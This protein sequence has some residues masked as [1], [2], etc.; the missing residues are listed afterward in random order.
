MVAI[1]AYTWHEWVEG[2]NT[3]VLYGQHLNACMDYVSALLNKG[4]TGANVATGGIDAGALIAADIVGETHLDYTRASGGRILQIGKN[5]ATVTGQM[6]VKGTS[7]ITAANTTNTDITVYFT[8]G[9]CCTAGDPAF[10]GVPMVWADV[11][12]ADKPAITIKACATNSC[13]INVDPASTA[14]FA[15]DWTVYWCAVGNK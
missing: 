11:Y 3:E 1:N 6:L 10:T 5:T 8:G 12:T 4:V 9:D 13:L 14:T 2:T 7:L 15:A